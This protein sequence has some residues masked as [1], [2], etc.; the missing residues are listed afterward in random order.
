MV[1]DDGSVHAAWHGGDRDSGRFRQW[2]AEWMAAQ[3]KATAN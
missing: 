1:A 3:P 2:C